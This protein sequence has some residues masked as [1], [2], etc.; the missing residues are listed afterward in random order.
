M[1]LCVHGQ[2]ICQQQPVHESLENSTSL[3]I[4]LSSCWRRCWGFCFLFHQSSKELLE[5][6]TNFK[7]TYDFAGWREW[8]GNIPP[9]K[10]L[11][12]KKLPNPENFLF[13]VASTSSGRYCWPDHPSG[14]IVY[15]F[16]FSFSHCTHPRH[17]PPTG[18]EKICMRMRECV[19]VWQ[20]SS[21]LALFGMWWT[22]IN[23]S[24]TS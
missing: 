4:E 5:A 8:P 15:H 7:Q 1:S 23:A 10:L 18:V 6:T 13:K 20:V 12:S 2:V 14:Y 9:A 3:L 19:R 22:L 17:L 24:S 16:L 21:F 11:L